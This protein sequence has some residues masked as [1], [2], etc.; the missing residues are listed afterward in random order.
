MSEMYDS[1]KKGLQEAVDYSKGKIPKAVVH[2]LASRC[3]E[4]SCKNCRK[5]K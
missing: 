4:R 5:S 3:E 1:I 2:D